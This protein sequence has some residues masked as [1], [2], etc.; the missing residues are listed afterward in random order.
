M[1]ESRGL[2]AALRFSIFPGKHRQTKNQNLAHRRGG[3]KETMTRADSFLPALALS[4]QFLYF[5]VTTMSPFQLP[6]E[7]ASTAAPSTVTTPFTT[8]LPSTV[9]LVR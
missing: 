3:T 6:P 2:F 7:V 5:G 8:E 1:D 4:A 9:R